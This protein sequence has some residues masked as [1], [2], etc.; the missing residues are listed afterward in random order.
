MDVVDDLMSPMGFP[1]TAD[2]AKVEASV[3]HSQSPPLDLSMLESVTMEA[4]IA[5]KG[6]MVELLKRLS[7]L[8]N[9]KNLIL[10]GTQNYYFEGMDNQLTKECFEGLST[11]TDSL[12][13]IE[14]MDFDSLAIASVCE[15]V[16]NSTVLKTVNLDQSNDAV[17][18]VEDDVIMIADALRSTTSVTKLSL[19]YIDVKSEI[20]LANALRDGN[21]SLLEFECQGRDYKSIRHCCKMNSIL[22]QLRHHNLSRDDIVQVCIPHL[23]DLSVVYGLLR[24]R[25]D[26]WSIPI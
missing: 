21:S 4:V 6:T 17:R 12:E 7:K 14:V 16:K 8:P 5:D 9:L 20:Y 13:S 2:A 26:L 1:R 24:F 3:I 22:P 15:L 25:P 19:S 23:N 10:D 18:I 11:F